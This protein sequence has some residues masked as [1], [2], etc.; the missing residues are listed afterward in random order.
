LTEAVGMQEQGNIDFV[1]NY[2]LGVFCPTTERI[3]GA[4]SDLEDPQRYAATLERLAA[5]VPRDGSAEIA[6]LVIEQMSLVRDL[7]PAA[8][9]RR[10][11]RAGGLRRLFRR[12]RV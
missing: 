8:V 3:V 4:V 12:R 1:L 6:H 10:R 9:R 2:E 5:S 7:G 11:P